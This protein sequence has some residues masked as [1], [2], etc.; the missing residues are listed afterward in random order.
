M[1]TRP[2]N[3]IDGFNL[4]APAY[5]LTTDILTLGFHRVWRN[6]FCK[7]FLKNTPQKGSLLDIATGTG[8]VLFRA[9]LK[10]PDIKAS[11]IDLS[12]GM[13]RIAS[14]KLIKK[15]LFYKDKIEFKLANA[16]ALPYSNDFFD[17]VT[18]CWSIRSLRP[19][20]SSLREALR[21][22]KPGGYLY[23]LEH[24]LPELKVVRSFLNK[25]TNSVPLIGS[26]IS[27]SKVLHPLYTTSVEE[28]SSGK[29]FAA[30]MFE[31]G[32]TKVNYESL[33]SGMIYIYKAQK[34]LK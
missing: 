2:G 15:T 34:T 1:V 30:E 6:Y 23:I 22:L 27:H 32:F 13:L 7:E 4:V 24:G 18:I 21:V 19:L 29:N 5:D 17:T 26:K 16:L 8:D 33:S 3:L 10:R 20:Q 11:G 28:F 14:Q 25:Y 31:A 12:E 9:L